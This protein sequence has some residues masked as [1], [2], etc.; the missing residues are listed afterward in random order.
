MPALRN[1]GREG[2][3]VAEQGTVQQAL[4]RGRGTSLRECGG[5]PGG[6]T[7]GSGRKHGAS[8]RS[9]VLGAMAGEAAPAS[10][11][12]DGSGRNLSRQEGQVPHG[13][14][15]SGDGGAVVVWQGAEEGDVG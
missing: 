13:S 12:A 1:T 6:A 10:A 11:T 9:A 7:D 14:V 2:C 15:Q 8:H 5:A 4:R 3:T